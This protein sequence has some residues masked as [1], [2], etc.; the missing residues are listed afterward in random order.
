[1]HDLITELAQRLG[2]LL[3]RRKLMIATVE[4]CTGGMIGEVLT[5]IPGSSAWFERGFITYSNDAKQELVGVRSDT[6]RRHGAV[7]GEVAREMASGGVRSSHADLAVSVTGIAG[8]EG[9]SDEKPV[10]TV[11]IAW[12][13]RS[14]R[15]VDES[16][17]FVGGRQRIREATAERALAGAIE[18]VGEE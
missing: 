5:R 16:F 6:L 10:G 9:G 17:Q 7:S 2:R 8:P 1:M 18:F 15:V 4:S 12:S 11:W 14:G 3:S 13:D